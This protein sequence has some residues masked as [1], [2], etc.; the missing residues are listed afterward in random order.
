MLPPRPPTVSKVQLDR[1]GLEILE[2]RECFDLL[3][4]VGIRRVALSVR[5]LPVVLPVHFAVMDGK[6]VVRTVPGTKLDAALAGAVVAFEA[7]DVTEDGEDGW[8]VMVQGQASLIDDESELE[9]ARALGLRPWIGSSNDHFMSI[10]A[11]VV[12]GR[13]RPVLESA[14][15]GVAAPR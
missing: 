3:G 9:Q 10:S 1:N 12:T 11:D 14:E 4:T 6:V 5:A 15:D 8:S 13:R 2:A 7:D